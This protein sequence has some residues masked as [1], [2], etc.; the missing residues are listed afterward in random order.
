MKIRLTNYDVGYSP[1]QKLVNQTHLE[2][3]GMSIHVWHCII[4]LLTLKDMHKNKSTMPTMKK[5]IVS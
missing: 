1:N 2:T 3:N 5:L 4:V